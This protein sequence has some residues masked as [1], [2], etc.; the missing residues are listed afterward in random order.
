[1][2]IKK[3]IGWSLGIGGTLASAVLLKKALPKEVADVAVKAVTEP[4]KTFGGV[5]L[6][7][8]N[9]IAKAI[10]PRNWVSLDQWGFLVLH[11]KS[12]RGHQTFTTQMDIDDALKLVNLNGGPVFPGQRYSHAGEFVKR[13]NEALQFTKPRK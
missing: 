13:V 12:N 6:S 2:N 5:P 3:V 10:D 7:K 4:E 9:E 8:L 1:M 11:Y